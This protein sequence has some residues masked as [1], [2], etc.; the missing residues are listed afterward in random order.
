MSA[1]LLARA[2]LTALAAG[3]GVAPLFIDLNR[4]HAT[5][6]LWPGHARFH[7]VAQNFA[8]LFT[9]AATLAL[10]WW[11]APAA[12]LRFHLALLLTAAP[13][14]AFLLAIFAR[15]LY[16]GTLHDPGGIPP[17]RLRL[18]ARTLSVNVNVVLIL[19]AAVLLLAAAVLY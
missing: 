4:T 1:P 2:L 13:V 17:A 12:S 6:P 5:H 3:Q 18:G 15:P 10:L 16:R 7:L 11:P 9:A 8:Q 14:A 19:A